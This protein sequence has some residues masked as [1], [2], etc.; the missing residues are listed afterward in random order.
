MNQRI[1]DHV[2]AYN[3]SQGFSEDDQ[4]IIETIR[5][6]KVIWQGDFEK[7]RWW[8]CCFSVVKINEMLI[9]YD[10]AIT[11][12]DENAS[13]KGWDFDPSSIV[14]VVAQTE[15]ITTYKPL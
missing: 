6:A 1:K 7:H 15:T 9:G 4:A 10:D 5:D 12:G 8:T 14:E 13:E 3:R 2:A 11:T